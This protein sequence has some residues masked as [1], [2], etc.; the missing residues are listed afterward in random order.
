[1]IC[2]RRSTQGGPR[3]RKVRAPELAEKKRRANN[4]QQ[5]QEDMEG[6]IVFEQSTG[7]F[8]VINKGDLI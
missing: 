3:R 8:V 6:T 2:S 5:L 1:M 4:R 7:R